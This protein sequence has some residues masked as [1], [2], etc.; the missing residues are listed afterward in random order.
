MHRH[1]PIVADASCSSFKASLQMC[2]EKKPCHLSHLVLTLHFNHILSYNHRGCLKLS[3]N[4]IISSGLWD[5]EGGTKTWSAWW[6]AWRRWG[7]QFMCSDKATYNCTTQHVHRCCF[8]L[9][10]QQNLLNGTSIDWRFSSTTRNDPSFN[11]TQHLT[12]TDAPHLWTLETR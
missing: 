7:L 3:R 10:S 1:S 2:V 9:P 8:V 6:P 5:F 12:R 11:I 4:Y